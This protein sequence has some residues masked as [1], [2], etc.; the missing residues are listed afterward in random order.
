MDTGCRKCILQRQYE[1]S[2]LDLG[3]ILNYKLIK[4]QGKRWRD[5][6]IPFSQVKSRTKLQSDISSLQIMP[7]QQSSLFSH[8]TPLPRHSSW[9]VG[10]S[11]L[12]SFLHVPEQQLS[13]I[14]K[15]SVISHIS[16]ISRHDP[17]K[18]YHILWKFEIM[19]ARLNL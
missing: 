14:S 13:V 3:S 10:K 8:M 15:S 12:E 16:S 18:Y 2:W 7:E 1:L 17:V 11:E 4:R 5:H 6:Y 9:H 19:V